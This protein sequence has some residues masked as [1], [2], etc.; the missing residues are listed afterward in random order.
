[1]KQ[2]RY[3]LQ[4]SKISEMMKSNSLDVFSFLLPL[5]LVYSFLKSL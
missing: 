4:A 1:M 2:G 5:I 3:D